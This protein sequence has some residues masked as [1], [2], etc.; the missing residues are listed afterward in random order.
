M[1]I[2]FFDFCKG[3]KLVIPFIS[4]C[5]RC[6]KSFVVAQDLTVHMRTKSCQLEEQPPKKFICSSCPYSSDSE[7]HLLFHEALHID[8]IHMYPDMDSAN[9][10]KATPHHRCPKCDKLFPKS[11]LLGHLRLHTSERPYS[12]SFCDKTFV[13]KNNWVYHEKKH[14]SSSKTDMKME[15]QGDDERPF[16]CSTCGASFKKR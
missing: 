6:A 14:T 11:S 2:K 15:E 3:C 9:D 7:A 5:P 16:L 10:K 13:R 8:P 1:S 4:R 12:C